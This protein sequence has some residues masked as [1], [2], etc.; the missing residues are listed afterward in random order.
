MQLRLLMLLE[1]RSFIQERRQASMA[2]LVLHF[3]Q[4]AAALRPMVE[5]WIEKGQLMRLETATC[6]GCTQCEA[7]QLEVYRY[8]DANLI[9]SSEPIRPIGC[10]R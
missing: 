8:R 4:P 7:E 2:E 1:I 9:A 5:R 6:S 10:S 3:R